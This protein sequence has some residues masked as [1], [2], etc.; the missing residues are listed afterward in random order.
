MII[1][2]NRIAFISDTHFGSKNEDLYAVNKTLEIIDKNNIKTIF[3][4]GDLVDGILSYSTEGLKVIG[5]KEQADHF[6]YNYPK[7]SGIKTHCI[8]GN[9]D[10]SHMY[11]NNFDI[12]K[13][14][15]SK[16]KDII[17]FQKAPSPIFI[18]N[19][20]IIMAHYFSNNILYNAKALI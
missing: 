4:L 12:L 5:A 19:V 16:R 7:V 3:H 18:N 17:Y 10:N 8:K 9:H 6:I 13:Y 11:N 20:R 15:A 1:T 14:I 2:D